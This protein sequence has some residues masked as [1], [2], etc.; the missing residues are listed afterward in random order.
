V[1]WHIPPE[2]RKPGL[3]G[4]SHF[5]VMPHILRFIS[6]EKRLRPTLVGSEGQFQGHPQPRIERGWCSLPWPVEA[7]NGGQHDTR[8]AT[9]LAHR[10]GSQQH[11]RLRRLEVKH[12][13]PALS[14]R[15]RAI[16][17]REA[18]VEGDLA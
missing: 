1:L 3:R 2:W 9:M 18:Q 4:P 10:P 6:D 15:G 17:E 12:Q 13:H 8:H 14:L 7:A 11:R 16:G 5:P